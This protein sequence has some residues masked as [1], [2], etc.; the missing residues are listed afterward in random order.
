MFNNNIEFTWTSLTFNL[1][2][3][4]WVMHSTV[5]IIKILLCSIHLCICIFVFPISRLIFLYRKVVGFC[6]LPIL[7]GHFLHLSLCFQYPLIVCVYA[8]FVY[9]NLDWIQNV[10]RKKL[11]C[12]QLRNCCTIY[13][14]CFFA[15]YLH[16]NLSEKNREV[17]LCS[18][19]F[20]N[21]K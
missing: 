2:T 8:R 4:Q 1:L 17:K 19:Y 13:L 18:L 14:K 16:L 21:C 10:V 7:W 6:M 9:Y 5:I 15:V 3:Y 20:M 11:V 12:L